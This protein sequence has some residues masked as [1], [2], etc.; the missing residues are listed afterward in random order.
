MAGLFHG[1]ACVRYIRSMKSMPTLLANPLTT[2]LVVDDDTFSRAIALK[3]LA[4]LGFTECAVAQ[5]GVEGLRSLSHMACEPQLILCDIF[6]PNK[7]GIEFLDALAKRGFLGQVVL[8]SGGDPVML[9][10]AEK[11]ASYG[12][13]NVTATIAKPL[14]RDQLAQA[15]G[16]AL[17]A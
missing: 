4:S 13:L 1:A 6:M 15:I 8:V 5:D 17:V 9:E 10:V 14:D 12:G 11:L 2:A 7:D 3:V 16:V